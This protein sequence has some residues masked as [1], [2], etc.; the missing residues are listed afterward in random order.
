M[1]N[2]LAVDKAGNIYVVDTRNRRVQRISATDGSM[3]VWGE[4]DARSL[5]SPLG[6]AVDSTG[7][8]LV[9]DV[10]VAQQCNRNGGS[11]FSP[12]GGVTCVA[13]ASRVV[14]FA[15]SGTRLAEWTT[16]TPAG[17]RFLALNAIAVDGRDR[18]Y[19]SDSERACISTLSSDGTPLAWK[20]D[21]STACPSLPADTM[22]P[23]RPGG[24]TLGPDGS[25]YFT[26]R[27]PSR[28][29]KLA[30]D[31]RRLAA[32]SQTSR[33]PRIPASGPDRTVD[34]PFMMMSIAADA[35]ENVYVIPYDR[36]ALEGSPVRKI[37]PSGE[38]SRTWSLEWLYQGIIVERPRAV[39]VGPDGSI[40]TAGG[41]APTHVGLTSFVRRHD[42]RG[43]LTGWWGRQAPG[44]EPIDMARVMAIDGRGFV[45]VSSGR[46]GDDG[47]VQKLAPNG[48]I[49]ATWDTRS[50]GPPDRPWPARFDGFSVD[51]KGYLY[52]IDLT[53]TT[54]AKVDPAGRLVSRRT[55]GPA[56]ESV[57]WVSRGIAVAPDGN[58]YVADAEGSRVLKL[59]SDGAL[60]QEWGPGSEPGQFSVPGDLV[61]DVHGNV[62]V[63]D[64]GNARIQKLQVRASHAGQS[65]S[66]KA[67]GTHL[68]AP[69]G[70]IRS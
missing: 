25:I 41:S 22:P 10:H 26:E 30:P 12:G 52:A 66:D 3:T 14:K 11:P 39:R 65:R 63:V 61:T 18:V 7:A 8:V 5:V 55:I 13:G 16:A 46:E 69:A 34:D 50:W 37:A 70:E 1:P 28:V 32:W 35:D 51:D 29:V 56:R 33:A 31:G 15:A 49:I 36:F 62:Y 54:V 27:L 6:V 23:D 45:Y 60:L 44:D 68:A 43:R 58:V 59:S 24:L 20:A 57:R 17:D 42:P 67:R 38:V 4:A 48:Q 2:G 9:T 47:T 53:G 19:V 21:A 64:A 40:F